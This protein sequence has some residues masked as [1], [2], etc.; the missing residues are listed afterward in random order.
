MR[1]VVRGAAVL[2]AGLLLAACTGLPTTGDVKVGEP[3]GEAPDELDF[4]PLADDPVQGAGPEAIVEGFLQAAITAEDSWAIARKFLTPD[5]ES[6]WQ[7]AA[8]VAID[9][10]AVGRTMTSSLEGEELEKASEVTV[11]V[12]VQQVASV[13]AQGEYTES[14]EP[15]TLPFRVERTAHGWRI[16]QAP[17]G[18][19]IERSW[20]S[21]VF[22]G[23]PLQYFDQTWKRMVPD[24]RWFPRRP[25]TATTI[26]QALVGGSPSPW[27][28][29]S[30]QN[31]FPHD[32]ELARDAVP[33]DAEGV[34]EVSLSEAASALDG[35]TL[36]RMRTQLEES[37]RAADLDVTAVRLTVGARPLQAA[38][39]PLTPPPQE[40]G[41]VVLTAQGFGAFSGGEITPIPRLSEEILGMAQ[42]ISAIDVATDQ[43]HAAVQLADGR[44]FLVGDG[45]V[46]EIDDK[47]RGLIRPSVDPFGFT[48]TVPSSDPDAVSVSASDAVPHGVVNAWPAATSISNL[49][50]SADGARVAAVLTLD[51][52][53]TVVIAAVVRDEGGMPLELGPVRVLG[54]LSAPST[55]L[56]WLSASQLGILTDPEDPTLVSQTVGGLATSEGAPVDA[57]GIAGARGGARVL[58]ADG[59]LFARGGTT[60]RQSGSGVVVLATRSGL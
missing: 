52:Q 55:G 27:L 16:A 49:R 57:V 51:G 23:Y 26:A 58:G 56:A 3:L 29:A 15:S 39:V 8:G 48:W 45:H 37:F 11:Q 14:V 18:I 9:D 12:Q 5:F 46:D 22:E 19:L 47:R 42:P 35:T 34:A 59:V 31:A 17:D 1:R 30:V 43:T 33:I 13:D 21:Q 6:R 38:L 44:V 41:P 53:R 36:A 54:K 20:F 4:L 32:V 40:G 2:M 24:V 60:W 28:E 7:P 50:V 25:A 10:D